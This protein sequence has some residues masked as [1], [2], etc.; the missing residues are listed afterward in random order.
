MKLSPVHNILFVEKAQRTLVTWNIHEFSFW[1]VVPTPCNNFPSPHDF[2][3]TLCEHYLN[4][5]RHV[6]VTWVT[7]T[8]LILLAEGG[9]VH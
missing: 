1:T 6:H 3:T 8:N 4:L 9:Q 7:N 2:H 5:R